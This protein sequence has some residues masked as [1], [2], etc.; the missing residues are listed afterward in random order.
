MVRG[1]VAVTNPGPLQPLSALP[2]LSAS[3]FPVSKPD[4]RGLLFRPRLEHIG[5]CLMQLDEFFTGKHIA[6]QKLPH[7]PAYTANRMAQ[8][9][10]VP[11]HEVAKTVLLRTGAGYA[12][13]VLPATHRLDLDELRA[14]LHDEHVDMASE[15]DMDQLFPDCERGAVPP[16]GSLYRL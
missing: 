4:E 14:C 10:H 5:R 11:G 16:F 9:L 13:A 3:L 2:K 8:A 1:L 12:V 6:F 7:R 15:N